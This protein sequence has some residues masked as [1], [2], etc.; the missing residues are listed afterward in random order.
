MK[1]RLLFNLPFWLGLT[2]LFLCRPLSAQE[3]NPED[4]R[5]K[6]SY[7]NL[8]LDLVFLDLKINYRLSFEFNPEDVRDLRITSY[9]TGKMPLKDGLALLLKGT[10]LRFKLEAPRTVSIFPYNPEEE[11]EVAV[12]VY[13]PEKFDFNAY[14]TIKD[15]NSGES[16]PFANILVRGSANGNG[17]SANVDGYFTLFNVPNDTAI[18]EVSYLGYHTKYFRLTPDMN[19]KNLLIE[20][21][22]MSQELAEVLVVAEE[23]E[24]LLKASTGISKMAISPLAM[25]TLPS[26]GEKDIFRSLQLLPGISGSNE[27]SSGLYVRGGTPDQNLV[28]F[29]GFTVYH[30][31]HLFG[32]FSAFN[33]NAIKDVQLYKGGFDAKFGGRLSSVVELTGKDG[34]TEH[35]N[36]G[37]GL[38]LLS[39]NA[40]LES[41]FAKGK[42]SFLIAGRRSFQSNFY[43]NL[44]D[45][46]TQTNQTGPGGQ[47][48]GPP[49][50][51]NQ[52][53][54][55]NSFFYDLNAKVTYRPSK[56]DIFS[57]SFFNGQDDLDNSRD[58]DDNVFRRFGQN[59]DF[60][61]QRTSTDLTKWGN[62]GTSAKWS[63]RWNDSFYSNANI[64]YSNYYSERDRGDQTAITR[65]DTAFSVSNGTFEY[66]NLRDYTLKLDNEWKQG[67]NNQIEFGLQSTYQDINYQY[68]QNDTLEILNRNNRGWTHAGYLQDRFVAW[69]KLILKGG[70]RATYYEPTGAFYPEPRV[71]A[72][73]L[74]SDR[75]K[76]KG[77]WGLY[78]QFAT[79]VVR[80]DIQQGS[81]DFWLLADDLRI[82]VATAVHYIVGASYETPRYLFDLEL[83]VKHLDGLTEY[84]TRFVPSGFGP[85]R[86]LNYEEFFYTGTGKAK[87]LEFLLQK[88][89]GRLTGWVG[90]TLS[91]VKYQ[92]DA[93][94]ETPFYANQDQT[95]ELKWVGNY[96]LN[97]R[98]TF[99]AT[100][101]YATGKPYTA[102][103]GYY[104]L[105]L[106]DG[107]SANF[108]E[109]SGK[110]AL[111]LPDYHRFDLSATYDFHLGRSKANLGLSIF[112]VYNR[113]NVWYKEYEVVEDELL[114]TNV[115]LLSLTP[116]LFFNW[117]LK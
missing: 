75:W 99:G 87:G 56:K 42:G 59:L 78:R 33:S 109:I 85:D 90:Y 34:N 89:T 65:T 82:P 71:S 37:L 15:V 58:A 27:S 46:F 73:F 91:G 26:F 32:F 18:L 16:L 98:F 40:F 80:E 74:L 111:R 115:T 49:G 43:S 5:I 96:R 92:F 10:H 50:F 25:A 17:T 116:S 11:E 94:G 28:L 102:P 6:F 101:I 114:E 86:T 53:V 84:T 23:E 55:P 113:Q 70:F 60:N 110:N 68:I 8:S 112:N 21:Q 97:E 72:T 81:R 77:A 69:E 41:P 83:Y 45:A 62:W 57:F 24:K 13:Q 39:V 95:H 1:P 9:S 88:K 36:A 61:F 105:E 19:M 52:N 30:V 93:F 108:F 76:I 3:Q 66:N 35:L 12:S 20:M 47:P 2:G 106:L 4:I 51:A 38:S 54:R 7:S 107:S 67:K 14:G 31:D 48:G 44:F 22:D 103:T 117:T 64:S 100:F 29:D 79:R 104:Q 63:R